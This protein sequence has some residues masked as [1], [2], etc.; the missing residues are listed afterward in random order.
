MEILSACGF[1]CDLCAAFYK[2]IQ[3]D[4]QRQKVSDDWFYYF[5]FRIPAEEINCKG[6]L[7]EDKPLDTQCSVR[8]CVIERHFKNCAYCSDFVCS[9]LSERIDFIDGVKKKFP[10]LPLDAYE[11]YIRPY[12]S[13]ERL[14]KQRNIIL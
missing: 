11:A 1:R 2:N 4:A 7:D 13:R 9:K 10:N 14:L 5:G 12:E 8:P 3:S 6:C